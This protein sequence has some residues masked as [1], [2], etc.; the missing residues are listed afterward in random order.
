MY[1]RKVPANVS[2][3]VG[4]SPGSIKLGNILIS[5]FDGDKINSLLII[6]L[7]FYVKSWEVKGLLELSITKFFLFE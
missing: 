7:C 5:C 2:A 3:V 4:S 1:C 6:D